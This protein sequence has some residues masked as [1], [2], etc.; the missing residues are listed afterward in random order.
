MERFRNTMVDCN[1]GDLGYRGSKYTWS[2]KQDSGSFIKERLDRAVAT[3]KWCSL[4][5]NV[6]IEVLSVSNSDHK[7]LLLRFNTTYREPPR[8]FRYEAKWN[9]DVECADVIK[10]V[11]SEQENGNDPMR[12]VMQKLSKSKNA[13]FEW[14][15]AKYEAT[16]RT[17]KHLS[18]KL[19]RLQ[20]MEHPGNLSTIRQV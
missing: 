16:N 1:L 18:K 11:W 13:L 19:E 9:L 12:S 14:S 3:P 20:N 15:Q 6:V 5:P 2:N 17:I 8:L 4:F 10:E 7:P